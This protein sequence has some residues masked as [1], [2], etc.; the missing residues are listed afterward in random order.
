M[1]DRRR[2]GKFMIFKAY[3]ETTLLHEEADTFRTLLQIH[4]FTW[5]EEPVG[6]YLINFKRGP[7]NL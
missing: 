6:E 4:G 1:N 7:L 3:G 2:K 5:E